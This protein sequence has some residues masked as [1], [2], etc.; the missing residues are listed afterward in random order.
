MAAGDTTVGSTPS[1]TD[2]K[3]I[4]GTASPANRLG[5]AIQLGALRFLGFCPDDLGTAPEAVVAYVARQLD[6]APGELARYGQRGQARTEHLRQIRR[7]LGFHKATAGDLAQ[8]ESWLTDRALEH[9]R[10]TLLLWLACE[11]LLGLRVERPGVTHLER[12]VAAARQ[13]AQRKT[14]RRLTPI[15]TGDCKV[16]LDGLLTVDLAIGRSRLAWLQKSV[17]SSTPP[18]VLVTLEKRAFCQGWGVDRWDVSSLSPNR[19]KFLA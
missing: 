18:T 2:R 3:Q 16:R 9:D 10:P 17:A 4:P 19:L 14:Y 1:R 13:R 8:L 12:L 15:L 6:V 5:F 7:Y 11:H